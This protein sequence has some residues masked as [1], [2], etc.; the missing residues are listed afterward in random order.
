[1]PDD[2]REQTQDAEFDRVA[3]L[4]VEALELD[5]DA[6][7][8]FITRLRERDATLAEQL[9]SLLGAHA[10]DPDF[11]AEPIS[12]EFAG[13][14]GVQLDD[15]LVGRR[16]GSWQVD[17]VLHQG[18]M[19]VVYKAHRLDVD[20]EQHA[21]LK[22]IRF[23]LRS[24]EMLRR[25]GQERRLLA[26]LEH[27]NIARLL[28]GGTTDAGLPFLVMEHVRGETIDAWCDRVRP[29]T[30]E[31]LDVTSQVCSA[32]D[33]AHRNLV[34]HQDIKPA[35]IL[36]TENGTAK[37]LDF[38]IA[39][40]ERQATGE[41]EA[42]GS[43]LLTPDYA[44]PEQF[45]GDA[46]ST[47]T[48]TYSLGV[49]LY[50][51]LTGLLPYR[52]V[53]GQG[54]VEAGRIVLESMPD[55]PSLVISRNGRRLPPRAE[56]LDAVILKALAKQPRDRYESVAS[57]ADDLRRYR[58]GL[59]VLAR[60]QRL[61]YRLARFAGRNWASLAAAS[62]IV[63]A[64][65]GGLAAA[66]WQAQ[67]AQRQRDLARSE[68]VTAASAVAFLKTVL[69]S[70]DPWRD[71]EPS[72]SVEDVIRIAES[73]LDTVLA[74][75]PAARAYVLAALG[76]VAAGRG[77]VERAD[78]F[79]QRAIALLDDSLGGEATQAGAIRHARAL[80][81]HELGQLDEAR[82]QSLKAVEEF[83]A[84][85]AESW[86]LLS[87]ALNQLGALELDRGE[88]DAA[89]QTLRRAAALFVERSD[90]MRPELAGVLN[91]LAV[92]LASRPDRLEEAAQAYADAL[93]IVEH[94]GG[95]GPRLATLYANQ[96]N[97]YRLM[98]RYDVAETHFD[99]AIAL[100]TGSLGAE[101]P[102]TLTAAAS[103]GSMYEVAGRYE[104]AIQVLRG[105]LALARSSLPTD[106]PATAYIENVLATALC[107]R[108]DPSGFEEGLAAARSSLATRQASLGPDHWGVAS[109]EA[110]VGLCLARLG[111]Q[112]SGAQM[113]RRAWSTLR[114]QRGEKHELTE[115]AARWLGETAERELR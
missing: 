111:N 109:T 36:V 12:G 38:G 107:Q 77:D 73:Q 18:G 114:E 100:L 39:D 5:P 1:M 81:L 101:H 59:P 47:A 10:S 28:D 74:A 15:A 11:L 92:V 50:R 86:H 56:D 35:N 80:A 76:E 45:R 41:D 113:L 105:P 66:L 37:L 7:L 99:R 46:S 13:V 110:I 31:L 14:L 51:L 21:A 16:I 8:A 57:F 93:R 25:F 29:D 98:G 44:S 91:N 102:A 19:G 78:R 54:R 64:L 108:S 27:P 20:F 34:I 60:P 52:I 49:L 2:N 55:A 82:T 23:G 85:G 62:A 67:L 24:P 53:P 40:L 106:H 3:D 17:E 43:I 115:R 71:S 30:G 61:G 32:V 94:N 95:S 48:D 42:P 26:R 83:G 89:E 33:F 104:D 90:T 22:V 87:S 9:A 79:T 63:I 103:L 112:E 58:V 68:S 84:A 65:V 96:A 69:G 6:Q 88:L 70:A 4:F 75:E 72:E 97:V